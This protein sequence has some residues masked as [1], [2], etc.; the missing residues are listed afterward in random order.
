MAFPTQTP[1]IRDRCDR[2]RRGPVLP[3]MPPL[4]CIVVSHDYE[5]L[6][7]L[8]SGMSGGAGAAE[9]ILAPIRLTMTRGDADVD[10]IE[11]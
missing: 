10:L 1:I 9:W 4:Y 5:T 6:H 7:V 3:F 2:G 8:M 11:L